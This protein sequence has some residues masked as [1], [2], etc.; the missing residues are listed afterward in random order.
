[1]MRK[2]FTV[3]YFKT[4]TTSYSAAMKQLG[5]VDLHFPPR[6][7]WQLI[8]TGNI[9]PLNPTGYNLHWDSISNLHE[10]EWR[11]CLELLPD[12]LFVLTTRDVDK[13]LES[14][15][16]FMTRKNT[17]IIKQRFNQVFGIPC[18]QEAFNSAYLKTMFLNHETEIV[19]TIPKDQLLILNLDK[20]SNDLFGDLESF[21]RQLPKNIRI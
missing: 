2:V 11:Q 20:N 6:H 7:A 17:E 13:W 5:Y 21:M 9:M 16:S 1:M 18:D 12:S 19:D 14:I 3:G 15:Q 8:K 4:G 10:I